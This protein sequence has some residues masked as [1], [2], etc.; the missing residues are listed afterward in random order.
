MEKFISLPVEKQNKIIDA[1]LL[2]FGANGYKKASA[3][4]IA[5]AAG[6][7]KAMVFHYFGTKKEL[8]L[9]LVNYCSDI[10]IKEINDK[11]DNTITDFF[12]RILLSSEIKLSALN[13]HPAIISFLSS[14]YFENDESVKEDIKALLSQGEEYRNKI[15]FD[16]I[17]TSKFKDGINPQLV[18]KILVWMAEG[19][20]SGVKV[21]SFTEESLNKFIEE[22]YECMNLLKNNFYKEEYL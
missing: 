16:N 12:D 19:F 14:A 1:A 17:D 21:V 22:Y 6:I 10:I 4:D 18:F 15:A 3:S 5:A 7:S 13:K 9:F 2:S 11:F 20:A 8:Y